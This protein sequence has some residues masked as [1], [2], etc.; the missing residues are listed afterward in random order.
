KKS[1]IMNIMNK[2]NPMRLLTAVTFIALLALQLSAQEK[3]DSVYTF[4]FFSGKDMFYVP[5]MNNGEELN[6]L[7]DYVERYKPMIADHKI[8]LL[9]DGYYTPGAG[10]RNIARIRSNRVKSE[11]I[12][13]KGLKED[14]FITHNQ[15]GKANYVTVRFD[16]LNGEEPF[17]PSVSDSVP[18]TTVQNIDSP[19]PAEPAPAEPV[20]ETP[21]EPVDTTT[22][23]PAPAGTYFEKTDSRFVLKTNLLAYAALMPNLELEWKFADRWSAA[24]EGQSAWYHRPTP[25][26]VYRVATLIPEL[27]Y[28]TIERSRWHG[29]YVGLFGGVGLYD[30]SNT[31]KGHKGEGAMVGLSA[32]YMWP[33][34]KHLSLDAGLGVGY[35]HTRDKVYTPHNGHYLY[36]L[37]KSFDYFGPLRLKLSLVY[38]FQC[39]NQ[40]VK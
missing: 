19:A 31:K 15:P 2:S 12:T 40:S 16:F 34:G 23:S 27:R 3:E 37:T 25:R 7:F 38:R 20:V 36:K 17:A 32:G 22:V 21:S 30:L 4:R 39:K 5:V 35:L 18:T 28:W 6:R 24:L 26:K 14:N 13:R 33:I 29:M 11:L 1:T 8:A 9:V 10:K